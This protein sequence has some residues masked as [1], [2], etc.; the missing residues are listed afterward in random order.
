MSEPVFADGPRAR[1]IEVRCERCGA[2][3][4]DAKPWR[5]VWSVAAI[6]IVS[7]D[8]HECGGRLLFAT[9]P[10]DLEPREEQAG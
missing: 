5:E 6:R 1:I 7:G 2:L 8:H 9:E 10:V 3:K 4:P